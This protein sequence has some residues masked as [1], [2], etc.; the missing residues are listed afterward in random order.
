MVHILSSF[1]SDAELL[2]ALFLQCINLICLQHHRVLCRR[3]ADQQT[4][5]NFY[6]GQLVRE[7]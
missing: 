4:G 2:S 5:F 1:F 3:Q 6:D 7:T